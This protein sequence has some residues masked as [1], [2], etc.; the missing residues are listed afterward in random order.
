MLGTEG[1]AARNVILLWGAPGTGRHFALAETARI[2]AARGFAERP[3]GGDGLGTLPRP[4]HG[5]TVLQDLYA[6]LH[7]PGEIVV[8]EHYES[9]HPGFLRILSDL[10]VKGSAPRPAGIW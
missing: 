6:A 10:A 3:D 5:K 9:C 2:M 7:A 4:R 1:A 8:F